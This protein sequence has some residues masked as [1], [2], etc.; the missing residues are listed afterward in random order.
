[1]ILIVE[2]ERLVARDLERRLSRLGYTVVAQVASGSE[3]IQ[4]TLAHRP[5]LV[6]MDIRL[7]GEMD[8]IEA[9]GFI[10]THL[11]TRVIYMSAYVDE[12]TLTRAQATHP[13]AF[14][15]KPFSE[16]SLQQTLQRVF[17]A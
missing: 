6:L 11:N 15:T 4:Q 12:A 17:C 5:D 13:A 16:S 7:K 8:G 9:A 2:D 3:A 14:L 1:N 10:R